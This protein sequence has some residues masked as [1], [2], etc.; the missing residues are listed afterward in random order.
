ME[1]SDSATTIHKSTP[2]IHSNLKLDPASTFSLMAW[3]GAQLAAGPAC[4]Q[5]E[6]TQPCRL[7]HHESP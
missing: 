2:K 5:K 6:T 4:V 3:E 1:G 7:L